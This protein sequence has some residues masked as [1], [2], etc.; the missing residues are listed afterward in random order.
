MS[1]A[2]FASAADDCLPDQF[3]PS[4]VPTS[5]RMRKSAIPPPQTKT[6]LTTRA[7]IIP[8]GPTFLVC[9]AVALSLLFIGTISLAFIADE[10]KP[11]VIVAVLNDVAANAPGIVLFGES[12]DVDVDEPSV[13]IRWTII[14]CGQGFVLEGSE[15]THG[16]EKCG[17]PPMAL[18]FFVD[19]NEEAAATYNP[20]L[21]PF[22]NRSGQR[23]SIQNMFQFDADHVLD[24][25]E[26]RFYPFD[27]Y[28]LTTSVRA[29]STADNAT[30]PIQSL[31]T[32]SLTSNFETISND[33]A[34]FVA[35]SNGSESTV[36]ARDLNLRITRPAEAR[37]YALLLFASSW[38]LAH[39]T[40]CLVVLGWRADRQEKMLQYL[41]VAFAITLLIPQMRNAMP[42]APGF[43]GVLIDAIG[44]FPQM[45]VCGVSAIILFTMMVKRELQYLDAPPPPADFKK[46]ASA[47]LSIGLQRMRRGGSSVDI[48]HFRNLSR[49]PR[50]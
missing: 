10:D 39:A 8:L 13:T 36:P 7:G 22:F 32:V 18:Q 37:A 50:M 12:V 49:M 41:V 5:R 27:T 38:M 11:P 48:S 34:S 19:G 26:A 16:T 25:H 1:T 15:G 24:V 45:L 46:E 14:G 29:V 6:P 30:L 40:M 28:L 20:D 33:V 47:P 9:M 17:L 35:A 42:D 43:D 44:F 4:G 3:A 2:S 31:G 23:H 21:L